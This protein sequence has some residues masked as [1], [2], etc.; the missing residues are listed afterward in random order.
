M[1]D[2]EEIQAKHIIF[3]LD[4]TLIDSAPTIL[5]SL[6]K[7]FYACGRTPLVPLVPTLI[8][9]PLIQILAQ[10]TGTD[11]P[12]VLGPILEAFKNHYDEVGFRQT[13][14]FPGISS[15]LGELQRRNH[16]LYLATNKRIVPTRKIIDLFEWQ[17]RFIAIYA[18][19]AY[20][21]ALSSKSDLLERIILEHE[22]DISETIYVGDRKEDEEA[23]MKN[24]IDFL[25]VKW[26]YFF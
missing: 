6:A 24:S 2:F 11:A 3:D 14:A 17:K 7:A 25:M 18:L 16:N 8:G 1:I 9:P 26:G 4:G 12:K 15:M 19:D 22:L 10:L 13:T 21:P 5:D 20:S 23:S